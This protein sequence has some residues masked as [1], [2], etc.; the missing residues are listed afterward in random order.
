MKS[1]R[2]LGRPALAALIVVVGL[3][4]FPFPRALAYSCDGYFCHYHMYA[5]SGAGANGTRGAITTPVTVNGVSTSNYDTITLSTWMYGSKGT[6]GLSSI[7]A[8]EAY[9][10]ANYCQTFVAYFHPYGTKDNGNTGVEACGTVLGSG[11]SYLVSAYHSGDH[12]KSRVQTGSTIVFDHDWGTYTDVFGYD[13]MSMYEVWGVQG[14]SVPSWST[15]SI[16]GLQW[17]NSSG[18]WSYWGYLNTSTDNQ[19]GCPYTSHYLSST[20]FQGYKTSDC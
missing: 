13:N 1:I 6:G 17:E 16:G 4:I 2:V 12:G 7:E 11:S 9:G 18:S 5:N 10:Y 14:Q 20:A 3:V 8:G 15:S 19:N